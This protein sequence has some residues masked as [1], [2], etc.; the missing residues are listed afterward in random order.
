MPVLTSRW[1]LVWSKNPLSARNL[2]ELT[3]CGALAASSAIGMLPQVVLSVKV[4]FALLSMVTAG[5]FFHCSLPGLPGAASSHGSGALLL[6]AAE[7]LAEEADASV[8]S[9]LPD[10]TRP[11]A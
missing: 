5:S 4:Y 1:H 10:E 3:V 11:P 2:K 8:L 7:G 6:A 9:F